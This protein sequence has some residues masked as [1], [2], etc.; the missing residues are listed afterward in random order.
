MRLSPSIRRLQWRVG[1]RLYAGARG[2][3]RRNLAT[4]NGE[5]YLQRAVIE[6]TA[7]ERAVCFMDIGANQG[8][9]SLPLLRALGGSQRTPQ[10]IKLHLFEPVPETRARLVSNI[11]KAQG[12]RLATIHAYALSDAAGTA[13]M[14]ILSET[15]GTNTLAVDEGTRVQAR[16]IIDVETMTLSAFCDLNAIDRVQLVKCDTEGHD[17]KVIRGAH[18]LLLQGRIDMLQF[19]YNHRW[20]FGRAYLKDVFDLIEGLPYRVARLLPGG[21]ETYDEWH[22][23]LERFFEANFVIVRKPVLHWLNVRQGTFDGANTYA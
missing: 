13:Q 22:P 15:G 1:R 10:T 23:E 5:T 21:I 2:E 11:A 9:W 6:A 7:A 17:A 18:P 12:R 16:R 8:D 4:D 20:V 14:A 3:P 19:E